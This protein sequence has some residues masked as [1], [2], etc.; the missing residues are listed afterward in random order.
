[1]KTLTF[2]QWIQ[3]KKR[4]KKTANN[5]AGAVNGTLAELVK[6]FENNNNFEKCREQLKDFE[7]FCDAGSL[8]YQSI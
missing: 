3:T 5:Y 6:Q 2:E 8:L 1:M 4:S 7:N